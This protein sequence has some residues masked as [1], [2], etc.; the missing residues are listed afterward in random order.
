MICMLPSLVLCA[1]HFGA[2]AA[3]RGKLTLARAI[4]LT[5][6][7]SKGL[8]ESFLAGHVLHDLEAA[9]CAMLCRMVPL[10]EGRVHEGTLECAYHGWEFDGSGRPVTIPQASS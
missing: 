3:S 1:A 5:A 2:Q 10:S 9:S 8:L 7:A 4:L 6:F